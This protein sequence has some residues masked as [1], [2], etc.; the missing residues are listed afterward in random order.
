MADWVSAIGSVFSAIAAFFSLAAFLYAMRM[1]REDSINDVRPEL[2]LL[3]WS[4]EDREYSNSGPC[5]SIKAARIKNVGRGPALDIWCTSIDPGDKDAIP[6]GVLACPYVAHGA[7]EAIEIGF[8]V[9]W[10]DKP[11]EE[12]KKG[13]IV[14]LHYSDLGRRQHSVDIHLV[15]ARKLNYQFAGGKQL[16]PRLFMTERRTTV[17]EEGIYTRI[18]GPLNKLRAWWREI[19]VDRWQV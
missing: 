10:S 7:E 5:T 16:V 17:T 15:L 3:D 18:Q 13:F 4:V 9:D 1:Q 6:T 14:R 2:L 11:F 19:T 12:K 8:H